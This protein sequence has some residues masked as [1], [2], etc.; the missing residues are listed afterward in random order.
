MKVWRLERYLNL[1]RNKKWV[2]WVFRWGKCLF[3]FSAVR[4]F[5]WPLEKMHLGTQAR[6]HE[7]R[8]VKCTPASSGLTRNLP[9]QNPKVRHEILMPSEDN[10]LKHKK[11][12]CCRLN[13]SA[14]LMNPER[15]S[16]YY[17]NHPI[18]WTAETGSLYSSQSWW[19]LTENFA[20][21][22]AFCQF[23]SRRKFCSLAW[24]ICMKKGL[25][26]CHLF[27]ASEQ[28]FWW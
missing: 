14:L 2:D 17:L 20:K 18:Y 28:N 24:I 11:E 21:H 13:K 27:P 23:F 25:C 22:S 15:R 4:C 8:A 12:D 19:G 6:Q 1:V 5:K 26:F 3:P 16:I 7:N 10:F 9:K